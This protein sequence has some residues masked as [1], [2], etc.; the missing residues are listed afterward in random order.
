MIR[1]YTTG[2][3][4]LRRGKLREARDEGERRPGR[5]DRSCEERDGRLELADRVS[6]HLMNASCPA[7]QP[8]LPQSHLSA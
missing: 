6:I 8:F 4:A 2:E 5:P 7:A 3:R 1:P